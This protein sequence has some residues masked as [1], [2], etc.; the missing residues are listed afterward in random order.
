[1]DGI[2]V[3]AI[4][5]LFSLKCHKKRVMA[6]KSQ[7]IIFHYHCGTLENAG[8]WTIFKLENSSFPIMFQSP[9]IYLNQTE[10]IISENAHAYLPLLN[11]FNC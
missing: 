2:K 6:G 10:D 11:Q 1:M 4:A 3:L 5:H 9:K 8:K 7:N